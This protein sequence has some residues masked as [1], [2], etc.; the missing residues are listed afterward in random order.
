M[1]HILNVGAALATDAVVELAVGAMHRAVLCNVAVHMVDVER[2]VLQ[3]TAELAPLTLWHDKLRHS[4]APEKRAAFVEAL[5]RHVRSGLTFAQFRTVNAPLEEARGKWLGRGSEG[6]VFV[7]LCAA[8]EAQ[9]PFVESRMCAALNECVAGRGGIVVLAAVNGAVRPEVRGM[10]ELSGGKAYGLSE[11][12]RLVEEQM[13]FVG[14]VKLCVG[15]LCTEVAMHP[16]PMPAVKSVRK[17]YACIKSFPKTVSVVGFTSL[18]AL[19]SVP[20]I[21]THALVP[22]GDLKEDESTFEAAFGEQDVRLDGLFDLLMSTLWTEQLVALVAFN[23]NW[24]GT[25][26]NPMGNCLYLNIHRPG[27][28]IA[29]YGNIS[30]DRLT[31]VEEERDGA[32]FLV[33]K[34][35]PR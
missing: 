18:K 16:D 20:C 10:C 22:Y 1:F 15:R 34:W 21:S 28:G 25:I 32:E 19:P 8:A 23:E 29:E 9:T 13:D 2:D 3:Q 35:Q 33:S 7:V 4:G 31:I 11:L 26:T 5:R 27:E 6:S 17:H 12:P 30:M 24:L 14:S